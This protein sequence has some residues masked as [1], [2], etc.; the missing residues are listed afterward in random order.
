[1]RSLSVYPPAISMI[2]L[3]MVTTLQHLSFWKASRVAYSRSL[4]TRVT[5][6][7]K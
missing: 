4:A 1:M 5:L 3:C 2:C 6:R 7:A